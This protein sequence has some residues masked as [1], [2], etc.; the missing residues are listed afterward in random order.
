[1]GALIVYFAWLQSICKSRPFCCLA[2]GRRLS[3][4]EGGRVVLAVGREV[5]EAVD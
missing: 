2:A 3:Q 1:M 4:R 5:A